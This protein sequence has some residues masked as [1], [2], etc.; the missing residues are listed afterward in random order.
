MYTKTPSS[1]SAAKRYLEA[2]YKNYPEYHEEGF[3]RMVN[4]FSND[5]F[6]KAHIVAKFYITQQ[7]MYGSEQSS[8]PKSAS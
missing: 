4:L 2:I 7:R 6:Y 8:S 5:Y 3:E 1:I